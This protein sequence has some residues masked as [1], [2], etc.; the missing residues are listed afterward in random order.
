MRLGGE[1][2]LGD[3][4]AGKVTR[5]TRRRTN[6]RRKGVVHSAAERNVLSLPPTAFAKPGGRDEGGEE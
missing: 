6:I 3:G 1:G 4:G 2:Q 5:M